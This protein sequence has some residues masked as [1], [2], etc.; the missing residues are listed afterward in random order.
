MDYN[1]II[2]DLDDTL[3][4][5]KGLAHLRRH[6]WQECYRQIPMV[7][8]LNIDLKVLLAL[9]KRNFKIGIVTNS[10]RTYA[11]KIL[12]FHKVPYDSLIAYHD[13]DR[14]KPHPDP[15]LKCAKLMGLQ[16]VSC[17]NIGDNINDM[18]AGL[19]A[20]MHCIGVVWGESNERDLRLAG[21]HNFFHSSDL[22]AKYLIKLKGE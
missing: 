10:P 1:G 4:N 2:F 6:N 22:L 18:V 20:N 13:T 12:D 11:E 15:M 21:C 7:T 9:K 5:T 14:R 8:K 19:K 16:P 3:V 17:I